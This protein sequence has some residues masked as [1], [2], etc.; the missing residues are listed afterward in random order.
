MLDNVYIKGNQ[1]NFISMIMIVKPGVFIA[2]Y[3]KNNDM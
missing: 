3:I 2:A 1:M